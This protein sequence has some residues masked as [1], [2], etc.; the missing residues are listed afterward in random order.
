[1]GNIYEAANMA[2]TLNQ[3]TDTL[4]QLQQDLDAMSKE[5]EQ[6]KATD[7]TALIKGITDALVQI[8][9]EY[10]KMNRD[11]VIKASEDIQR[12]LDNVARAVGYLTDGDKRRGSR[13]WGARY[14][15]T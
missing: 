13:D 2:A 5:A 12:G 7:S 6:R 14:A 3:I 9:E 11:A 10:T 1:M 4:T 15:R 8:G